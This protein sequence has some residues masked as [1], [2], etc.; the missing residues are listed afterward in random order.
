MLLAV[1]LWVAVSTAALTGSGVAATSN[2]TVTMSIPSVTSISLAGCPLAAR[3]FGTVL[4]D[5]P[6]TTQTDCSVQFGAT[7]ALS[8]LRVR[9]SDGA[10]AAMFTRT[11]GGGDASWGPGGVRDLAGGAGS[12]WL[13][14][15]VVTSTGQV[16]RGGNRGADYMVARLTTA[17]TL[18]TPAYGGDGY[19]NFDPTGTAAFNHAHVIDIFPDDSVVIG[20]HSAFGPQQQ[21]TF[22]KFT[23]AGV[24]DMTWGD[25]DDGFITF[26]VAAGSS[27]EPYDIQVLPDGSMLAVGF[28][29]ANRLWVA[30]LN[31]E[32]ELDTGFGGGDGISDFAPGATTRD[33]RII[34]DGP[35]QAFFWAGQVSNQ[36]YVAKFDRFGARVTTWGVGGVRQVDVPGS[37]IDRL[38]PGFIDSAG[39]L[40]VTGDASDGAL[41]YSLRL[42][43]AGAPDPTFGPGG[44]VTQDPFGVRETY[45]DG[46]ALIERG[47]DKFCGS[48]N[49][50]P[51]TTGTW[52][53]YAACFLANGTLDP[54]FGGGD[55]IADFSATSV[56]S[57]YGG[58][59]EHDGRIYV[60]GGD[61]NRLVAVRLGAD[62]STI[63]D[64]VHPGTNFT[65]GGGAFGAC[66]RARTNATATWTLAPL[67]SCDGSG[68]HWNGIARTTTAA[69]TEIAT[70]ASGVTNAVADLR[71]GVRS[72]AT[73]RGSYEAPITFEVLAP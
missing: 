48:G 57:I 3:G 21:A 43:A 17:G 61:V 20:G 40:V 66:L 50:E 14:G 35:S 19:A 18:D 39:R 70:A 67:G 24:R 60:G 49:G 8:R 34:V 1:A 25:G 46:G 6:T 59:A 45:L 33:G 52:R 62:T 56:E 53:I 9:Q 10:G 31:P 38:G 42:D 16:L 13:A 15:T 23:A 51:V 22:I 12:D 68:S 71:F 69:N 11:A 32:G 41:M 65:S 47:G 64:Y 29:Y 27:E 4:P 2:V 37:T 72:A 26:D 63:P 54:S 30:K 44:V 55:G 7:G 28:S 36:A 5:V 73:A 58:I